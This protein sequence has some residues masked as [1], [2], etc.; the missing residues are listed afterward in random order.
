MIT[1]R[2]ILQKARHHPISK[3]LTACK[4][5]VSGS[6][7]LPS[8]GA[9][10]RF[11]HSTRSLSVAISYLVLQ[12]GPR[13]FRQ[14]FTCLAVLKKYTNES[15][16]FRLRDFHPLRSAFPCCSTMIKI[17]YSFKRYCALLRI[18]LQPRLR[19]TTML[20]SYSV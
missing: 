11:L 17:S 4:S 20:H 1:R 18:L 8:R 10:H 2:L 15:L 7:S 12:G 6:L 16:S 9:F 3:A 5:M 19:N 13:R 14:G